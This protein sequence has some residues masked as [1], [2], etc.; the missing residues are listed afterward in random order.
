[1]LLATAVMLLLV[2]VLAA[3]TVMLSAPWLWELVLVPISSMLTR[4]PV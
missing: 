4:L 1:M 2:V 3:V